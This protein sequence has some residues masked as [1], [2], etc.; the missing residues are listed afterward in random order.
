MPE[1]VC[2]E[3]ARIEAEEGRK[4]TEAEA[5]KQRAK[6]AA[7]GEEAAVFAS[8][9]TD[10]FLK[11]LLAKHVDKLKVP[12][13]KATCIEHQI[14]LDKKAKRANI[15]KVIL[16]QEL[17]KILD[18]NVPRILWALPEDLCTCDLVDCCHCHNDRERDR[19]DDEPHDV[20]V[21]QIV[22]SFFWSK[23]GSLSLEWH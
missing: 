13:L 2:T 10:T 15:V 4:K 11:D 21:H 9:D 14:V 16:G 6:Y 3:A 18:E 1:R 17:V 19:V 8:I 20:V 22:H 5:A 7:K 12:E 23:K